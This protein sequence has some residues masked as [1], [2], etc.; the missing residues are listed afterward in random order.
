MK[1]MF[2]NPNKMEIDE[3]LN[4]IEEL[5]ENVKEYLNL[6]QARMSNNLT[7]KYE[8]IIKQ[9]NLSYSPKSINEVLRDLSSFAQGLVKWNDPGTMININ[10]PAT[11]AS[12]AASSYF[13]LFNPNGAQDMSCGH[14]LACELAVI[15]MVC[16]LVGWDIETAGGIFTFGGKSTN[17]HAIKQG[18]QRIDE[19]SIDEGVKDKIVCFSTTQGHICHKEVCGWLG[20]GENNC[21][22][23]RTD[24]NGVLDLTDLEDSMG[25]YIE[26]GYK[27]S[28]II[29][30]GCTT[31]QMTID[32]IKAVVEIRD[33]IVKEYKLS[34]K[35]RVHVDSVIGWVWLFFKYYNFEQNKLGFSTET[36]KKLQ[37][38][39]KKISEVEYADSFGVDF[40]KTGFASYISS[41]YMTKD[42][43]ELYLQGKRKPIK[44][45]EL[46]FGNY[47]PFEYTLE[48]SRSLEGPISAYVNLKLL[49]IEGYQKIMGGLLE[50]SQ[51]LKENLNSKDRC[52]V[53][54]MN[55]SDGFVTLF[56]VKEKNSKICFKQ[57]GS[58]DEE[59]VIKYAEYIHKF[60]M[61]LF[62]Q[63][64][65]GDCWFAIDYSSGYHVL[66][67]GKKIGVLKAYPMSP[68]FDKLKAKRFINDLLDFLD[69]FDKVKDDFVI[70]EVPHKPRPFVYR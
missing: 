39:S 46:E 29:I 31:L 56:I 21:I 22:R 24:I 70:K 19:K 13:S 65:K 60:Y 48:L 10:P 66:S 36:I 38:L 12:V 14:L 51:Y 42:R 26:N 9:E 11:I 18:I 47:S 34:Y 59:I 61:Y 8:D 67:S 58:E 7:E 15:K 32:P 45:S 5:H 57:L 63:Q 69:K 6:G 53:I 55:D 16:Q 44:Y 40:H 25:E 37:R 27:I 62:E 64:N 1:E 35:P 17:M 41:L 4:E 68:Y 33:R 3:F 50:A 23:L 52:E 54:N 2:L 49:G 30:N 20:I 43:N 28:T